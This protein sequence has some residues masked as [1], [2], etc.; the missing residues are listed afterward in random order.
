M[1]I[2]NSGTAR[3]P[4]W[5]LGCFSVMAALAACGSGTHEE[6][7]STRP[8]ADLIGAEYR[9]VADDLKAYGIYGSWPDKTVTAV[10]LIPGVGIGGREVAFRKEVPKGTLIKILSAWRQPLLFDNGVYYRVAIDHSDLP[11]GVPVEIEL[12]R[13]NET[14]DEHLN[15]NVYEK[16]PQDN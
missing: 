14:L 10:T 11:P 16:I 9:V 6:L 12:F 2:K 3:L 5:W 1:K 4:R 8:Y 15:P 13:G 7:T